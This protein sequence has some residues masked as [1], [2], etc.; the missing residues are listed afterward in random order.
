MFALPV[1]MLC[2]VAVPSDLGI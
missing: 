2:Q 1:N